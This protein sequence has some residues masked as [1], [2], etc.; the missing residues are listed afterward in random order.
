MEK[1]EFFFKMEGTKGV[2]FKTR[3]KISAKIR[4]KDNFLQFLPI[5]STNLRKDGQ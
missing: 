1:E 2:R 3:I 4:S 5:L